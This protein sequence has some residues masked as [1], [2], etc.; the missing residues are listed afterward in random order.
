MSKQTR[1]T[2]VRDIRRHPIYDYLDSLH[3][4]RIACLP[5]LSSTFKVSVPKDEDFVIRFPIMCD[6]KPL[7]ASML[8]GRDGSLVIFADQLLEIELVG[9]DAQRC[10]AAVAAGQ[11]GGRAGVRTPKRKRKAVG[12]SA[13]RRVS[14]SSS[15]PRR[16]PSS[17]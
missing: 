2:P 5:E 14:R 1:A 12:R 17:P 15:D 16:R 13:K 9:T 8:R 6:A 4:D 7:T 11:F 10:S 3:A